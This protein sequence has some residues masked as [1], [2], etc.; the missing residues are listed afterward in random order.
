M[1]ILPGGRALRITDTHEGM[2]ILMERPPCP[3]FAP[4]A[5]FCLTL[6]LSALLQ[7]SCPARM[8]EDLSARELKKKMDDGTRMAIVDVRTLREYQDGHVP[9]AINVPSNKLYLLRQTLPEDKTILIVFYCRGY[10]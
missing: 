7:T 3:R 6:V 4:S 2:T 9:A 1:R 10:G 8:F 5:A